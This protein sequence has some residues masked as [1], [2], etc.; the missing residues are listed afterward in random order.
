MYVIVYDFGTSAVK[1]CLFEISTSIRLLCHS[2]AEY[3]LYILENGGAEQDTEEW[4]SAITKTTKEL[5]TGTDVKPSEIAGISFCTQMQSVVL[6]DRDGNAL[7]RPMNFL[8]TRAVNEFKEGLGKGLIKVSGCNAVKLLRNLAVN[9]T[10]SMSA[11]DP[12]YKYKWVGKNE[13]DIFRQVYKWL[14]V[15]DYLRAR[16]TGNIA[17][18][19]DSA[20]ST[21]L[22][23]TRKGKEGWNTGL[24]RM[25]GV[26]TAHL[27]EL[28]EC[29]DVA[30][31]LTAKAAE[32]LG[33]PEGIPVFGGGGDATLTGIGAGCT[34][35]GQTH[36][37]VGTSGWVVT[38][39][40]HQAVDPLNSMTG[41]IAGLNGHFHYYAELETAGKC[42][43]WVKDHL[44]L[45]EVGVYSQKMNLSDNHESKYKS[46]YDY[47]SDEVSK[48]PPGS[49]G[50]I[51][52]PWMHG[53]RSPFEDPFAAGMFFNLKLETGKRDMI[54]SVLEGICFHLRWLLEC[55]SAKIKTSDTIRFVGGGALSPVTCQMLA[56]ITGREIETIDEPENAGAVGAALIIALGMKIIDSPEAAQ[57]MIPIKAV[58]HPDPAA[59]A[60]Y[61]RNYRV[62]RR[63]Y[64]CNAKNFKALNS[65]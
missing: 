20:F 37:Y 62:F 8:D 50:V 57:K 65:L 27:P 56:D 16:C 12:V 51:F 36:I 14:D 42:F 23:D 45:D 64:K 35:V 7:R 43:E 19:V 5:F 61:D 47:L 55:E 11:K 41:V 13:P 4:W 59:K 3:G 53:N 52:T 26:D 24:A 44:A 58:Y 17:R 28:I 49:H 33:L 9:K 6:V 40:D 46:L 10:A 29:T 15:N 30:G 32:E 21:F 39:M 63:L 38:L 22:Y 1:T 60:V 54:R 31:K 34:A 25:Y 18:T 48:V 2:N